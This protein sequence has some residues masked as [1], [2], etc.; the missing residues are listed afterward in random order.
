MRSTCLLFLALVGCGGRLH[1]E[2]TDDAATDADTDAPMTEVDAGPVAPTKDTVAP[3][4]KGC[5]EAT[6]SGATARVFFSRPVDD[7]SPDADLTV[8]IYGGLDPSTIDFTTP[9][10]VATEGVASP[11]P[12]DHCKTTH[13]V[14]RARDKAGN[15]DGNTHVVSPA[16]TDTSPCFAG[17]SGVTKVGPGRVKLTWAAGFDPVGK[18]ELVYEVYQADKPGGETMGK[19]TVTTPKGATSIELT[20]PVG[21][22]Y[23]LVRARTP[24]GGT[25]AN[26]VELS[27]YTGVS[28]AK[29]VMPVFLKSC[30]AGTCH[31]GTTPAAGLSL[32]LGKAYKATVG[33]PS[34]TKPG[35]L[36]VAPGDPANSVLLTWVA[37]VMP[38]LLLP[39]PGDIETLHHWVAE[40]A[41]DL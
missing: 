6:L 37:E 5:T 9:V 33:V 16:S 22:F 25:D 19:P 26:A 34:T 21:T 35:K 12:Y 27:L 4:F 7:H 10:V 18:S 17:L 15:E 8:R 3:S 29:E 2:S 23:W 32:E 14:C 31:R 13:Y 20:V 24:A 1:L 39:P 40:G 30:A 28:F 41:L 11:V 36:I 38:P